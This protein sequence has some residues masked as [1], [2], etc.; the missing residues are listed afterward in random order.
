MKKTRLQKS[1]ATVP[2]SMDICLPFIIFGYMQIFLVV[3]Q[4][5]WILGELCWVHIYCVGGVEVVQQVPPP[6]PPPH[7]A[8]NAH[9]NG[10]A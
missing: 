9:K 5:D 1:H 4:N 3:C 8:R 6:P 10:P 7:F 2:L